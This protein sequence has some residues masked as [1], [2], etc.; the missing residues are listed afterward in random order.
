M[1]PAPVWFGDH[2]NLRNMGERLLAFEAKPGLR[3]MVRVALAA[4]KA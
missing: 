1:K 3:K 4:L 2:R